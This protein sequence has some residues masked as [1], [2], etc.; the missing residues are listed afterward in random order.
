MPLIRIGFSVSKKA[1]FKR[2]ALIYLPVI[3]LLSIVI[4]LGIRLDGQSR[5]ERI[6]IREN[7]RVQIARELIAQDFSEA[8]SDLHVIASLTSLRHYLDSSNPARRDELAKVFV[9]LSKEKYHYDQVRLLNASGME[10][11]RVNYNDGQ[12]AVVPREQLQDKSDRYYFRESIKLGQGKTYVSPLDL[13][14]EQGQL[15]IPYKPMIRF[16]MPVFDSAGRKQGVIV[17]NYLGEKLLQDFRGSMQGGDPRNGMLLNREGYWLSSAKAEDEWGFMLGRNERTFGHDFPEQWRTISSSDAGTLL[18]DQG[19]FVYDTA[20]PL[21]TGK[22]APISSNMPRTSGQQES[23]GQEYYWK[24]VSFVPHEDLTGAAFYNQAGGKILLA[25]VY[26]LLALA[27]W[28]IAVV[29]LSRKQV[30]ADLLDA[31]AK[32]KRFGEAMNNVPAY[33]YIKSKQHQ[34]VYGNRQ[35]LELFQCSEEELP[36]SDDSEFFPPEAVARLR[37]VDDRVLE[38]G[39]TTREEIDVAPGTPNHRVYWEVKHPIYDDN[40]EIWGLSGI[41]TDITERKQAEQILALHAELVQQMAEGMVLIGAGNGVIEFVNPAFE[42][43][44]GYAPGELDGKQVAILNAPSDKT[45]EETAGAIMEALRQAGV[46]NGEIENVRKDG[47]RFWCL[48]GVSTFVHPKYGEVWLSIHQDITER[49]RIEDALRRSSEEIEDLYNHAPCG[50]HSLDEHGLIVRM[51]HSELEWL[52][53]SREEVVGKLHF[54]DLLIPHSQQ[55]FRENFPRFLKLGYVHDLEFE[56]RR[57]DGTV[58]PVLLSATAV[59]DADGRLIM[60]RSTIFDLTERKKLERELERQARIDMLTGLNNRRHFFELAEHELARARRHDEPLTVLMLDVDH[61]KRVNDTY[62]HHVG[63]MVLR[64]MSEVCTQTLR[65]NDILGR[66]GGEEFAILFP[67]TGRS[68]ALET[69]ERL[70]LAVANTD[71]QIAPGK[72]VRFTVSIGVAFFSAAD[73]NV[74]AILKRA[75]AVLYE[76]KNTGRNRVCSEA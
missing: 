67:E 39:E 69:A 51:N 20:N 41:S 42:R 58:L 61:F 9:L 17:L 3:A 13:N 32:A 21:L 72:S 44:F 57:K 2:A 31:L 11:I 55:T 45:P 40:G 36:D 47:T 63:D 34:Y 76:A 64:K 54:S 50:Y 25:M 71:V 28:I 26:L 6:G 24:V 23:N 46:W 59:R 18:T 60:S 10:I 56:V 74:D 66:M 30:R 43:M 49:K 37:E 12:P 27:A 53:Y 62:G 70:R 15:E 5:I 75:D 73:V 68:Q 29:T 14:I 7:S 19:L 16:G 1:I 38:R 4:L 65:E 35:V 33:V 8:D 52:G 48:A 22:R